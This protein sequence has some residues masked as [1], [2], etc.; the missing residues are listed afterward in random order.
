M[1]FLLS[2]LISYCSLKALTICLVEICSKVRP[3]LPV[4]TLN[5]TVMS[6]KRFAKASASSFFNAS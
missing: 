3:S 4:A 6:S 2:T 1:N 5:S